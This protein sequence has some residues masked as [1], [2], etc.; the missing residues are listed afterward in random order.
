MGR[1]QVISI[2]LASCEKTSVSLHNF[3]SLLI[4]ILLCCVYHFP[5]IIVPISCG[6]VSDAKF[7]VAPLDGSSLAS[8]PAY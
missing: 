7:I 2:I 1:E 6:F 3:P 4:F 8:P 5:H